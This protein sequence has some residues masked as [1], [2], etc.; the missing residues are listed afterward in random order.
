MKVLFVGLGGIGQRH[1][2][3]LRSI[4]GDNLDVI[5]FREKNSSSVI[6]DTLTIEE[7]SNVEQ[8]YGVTVYSSLIDALAQG[9]SIA[10]IC[11]PTSM[12]LATAKLAIEYGCH[13]FIEKA[14]SDSLDGVQELIR[15]ADEKKLVCMVG[16][17]MRFHPCLKTLQ[18]IL[19][20]GSLGKIV[21]VNA[22]VG[23]YMPAWH[24]YEDYRQLYAARKALGGGVVVSQIHEFDYIQWLFGF[25]TKIFASGGHL[26]SLE[27]DVEDVAS[28]TMECHKDGQLIPVHLHQ[29]YLQRPP[30]R[31][32]KVIG[33]RGKVELDFLGL[34]VSHY[35]EEGKVLSS[36][37]F[38]YFQRNQLFI[39]ELNHFLACIETGSSPTVTLRGGALSLQMAL[40]AKE[41]MH[42]GEV[43]K[44]KAWL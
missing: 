36:I 13:L 31:T 37:N 1:L 28:I 40:A 33:D 7:G 4:V 24:K 29:D 19:V 39:D 5:A 41:S 14:L 20:S 38:P 27:I 15:Q 26:S 23:E 6:S 34:T 42:T 12:H 25:P 22:E 32:C 18:D 16:Y 9:P 43:V 2:R 30:S 44:L 3:N 11:N 8:F 10:F 35:D 21:A 17:Q